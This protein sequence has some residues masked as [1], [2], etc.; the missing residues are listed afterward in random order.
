MKDSTRGSYYILHFMLCVVQ[1]NIIF[2]M[3]KECYGQKVKRINFSKWQSFK[4]NLIDQNVFGFKI[5]LMQ[6]YFEAK[7][8]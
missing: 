3:A 2:F 1:P 5:K 8:K 6:Q 4:I 7:K